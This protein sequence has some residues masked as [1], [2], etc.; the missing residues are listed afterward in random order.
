VSCPG[1]GSEESCSVQGQGVINL[2]TFFRWAGG[3]VI[4]SQRHHQGPSGSLWSGFHVLV[5][6]T[7]LIS[8][9]WWGSQPLQNSSKDMAQ[10]ISYSPWG[11]TKVF[12][13]VYW[14]IY[15]HFVLLEFSFLYFLTS[16]NKFILRLKFFYRQKA[17]G[18]HLWGSVLG[19]PHRVLL[20]SM[21]GSG[22]D[23]NILDI[24]GVFCIWGVYV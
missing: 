5:S 23:F 12:D 7:Q 6:S 16:L 13:F 20:L 17:G 2:W 21:A 18:R 19:R 1:R 8:L 15:Y 11:R 3:E 22:F 10:S 4:R 24:F 14:L 9:T